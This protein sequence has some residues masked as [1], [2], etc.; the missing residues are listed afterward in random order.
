MK[1]HDVQAMGEML[2]RL[3]ERE[4]ASAGAGLEARVT[5]QSAGSISP[6]ASAM[7]LGGDTGGRVGAWT[8]RIAA[9]VAIAGGVVAAWTARQAGTG[10]SEL[11][12]IAELEHAWS[13][14]EDRE[15]ST[16]DARIRDL[17]DEADRLD[18]WKDTMFDEG[19]M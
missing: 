7:R 18:G 2:D 19:A 8:I 5:L 16:L 13:Q 17:A 10:P 1:E 9:A 11:A 15:W 6:A 4:R 12:S 14:V 3:A